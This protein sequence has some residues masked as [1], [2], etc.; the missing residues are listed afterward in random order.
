MY[1]CICIYNLF[2]NVHVFQSWEGGQGRRKT[3]FLCM[4][5]KKWL[6]DV[7]VAQKMVC[8]TTAVKYS[9]DGSW[10]YVQG[11]SENLKLWKKWNSNT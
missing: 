5:L 6:V 10:K 8:T 11:G 1:A 4:L 2:L 3:S 7:V 9:L